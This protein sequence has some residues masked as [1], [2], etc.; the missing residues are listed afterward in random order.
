MSERDE[1]WDET[2]VAAMRE[3][4]LDVPLHQLLDL[5]VDDVG[6]P[7]TAS[8]SIPISA[9][10]LGRTGQLH[11]GAI[12]LLCDLVCAAAATTAS[13][14]DP[15]TQALVT[16]DLHVRATK[17][18]AVTGRADVVKAGRSL[19]V[20]EATVTDD[21]DNLVARADFS[22]TIVTPRPRLDE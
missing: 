5:Q 14:Y 4:F 11:G 10:A 17:G 22:A 18:R 6:R 19:V 15:M 1:G 13:T 2:M 20:V 9:N 8:M 12:A 7:G 16:A 3:A 21:L